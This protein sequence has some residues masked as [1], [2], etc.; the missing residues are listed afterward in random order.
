M[1]SDNAYTNL[2]PDDVLNTVDSFGYLSDGRLLALNSYEN[3][4][5]R[6]GLQDGSSVIVK[7]YRPNR[8]SNEAILEEHQFTIELQELEIPVIA[9]LTINDETLLT[10]DNYRLALFP[11]RGGRAPDLEDFDQ[12]EQMGR[13][14]GRIHQVGKNQT[15][16]HRPELN[17]DT[18]GKT[19]RSFILEH[20][21]IP[22]E[23]VAAYESLTT[24]LLDE[25]AMCYER[26]GDI[27]LIRCHGD[28]HPSNVLW[29]DNG[30]HIVDFDDAR[31]APAAQDI[32][33]FLA[34]SRADQTAFLD[35]VLTGYTEFCEF[36]PRELHLIEALRT[37]RLIHYYGW[38]AK[39]WDDP[40]FK[41]AFPW[42]NTQRC[43]EDHILS[44]RE[45]AALLHEAPLQ[46]FG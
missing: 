10:T 14:M 7:F 17:I 13:F 28:C 3:R 4:V 41:I 34:G 40:A 18:F 35:A 33:M 37:L 42:F 36:D 43:W 31:M 16:T 20:N 27:N 19:A 26:A 22:R 8:W 9:P 46:W 44:L 29:T 38:L 6:V 1:I 12:L 25:A 39:R 21:F 30:P 23:L 32:W 11:N 24:Q 5:Y 45:Q 2:S 15:F